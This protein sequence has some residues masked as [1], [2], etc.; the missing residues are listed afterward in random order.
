VAPSSRRTPPPATDARAARWPPSRASSTRS[1]GD[2]GELRELSLR[3][4]WLAHALLLAFDGLPLLYMGDELALLNDWRYREDPALADDN[5]WLHRPAMD[6]AAAAR[7]AEPG[8]WRPA[9]SAVS[10]TS[11]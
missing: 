4:I 7:R 11:S 8:P 1:S 9:S 10:A 3:R 2:D 5:R 6:W